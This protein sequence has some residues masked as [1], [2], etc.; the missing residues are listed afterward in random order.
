MSEQAIEAATAP[1]AARVVVVHGKADGFVQEVTAGMHRLA[2]DEPK[3]AG[4][5]ETGPDPYALL[6]AS[7]GACTSMTIGAYARRK[8]WPLDAVTVVLSHSRAHAT[9]CKECENKERKLDRV[10]REI[11]LHGALSP[12]QQAR[13]LE[14]ADRCPLH[15]T[16]AAGIE[17][18]TSL[19]QQ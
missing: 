4:G 10:E 5:T 12:E 14:I 18:E 13:L 19:R 16:L 1:A 15:R 3:T 9:D 17:V 7:L 8:K 6:L 2:V 11:A